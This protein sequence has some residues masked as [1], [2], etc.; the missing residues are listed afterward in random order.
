MRVAITNSDQKEVQGL[1]SL[2]NDSF[3]TC[4][5]TEADKIRDIIDSCDVLIIDFNH[6]P[7]QGI[8]LLMNIDS[9]SHLP[10]VGRKKLHMIRT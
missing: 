8:N 2:L 5:I 1:R 10:A 6:S 3:E 9:M 7:D 4:V